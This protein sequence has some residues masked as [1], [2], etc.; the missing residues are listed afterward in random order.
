MRVQGDIGSIAVRKTV[1]SVKGL[2]G[3][4]IGLFVE[5]INA[6]HADTAALICALGTGWVGVGC[7]CPGDRDRGCKGFIK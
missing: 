7:L 6:I 3:L 4:F 1:C 2:H 5:K